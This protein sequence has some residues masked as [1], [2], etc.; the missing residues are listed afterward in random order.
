MT[1]IEPGERFTIAYGKDKKPLEVVAL[2]GRQKRRAVA[3]MASTTGASKPGEILA[4]LDELDAVTRICAPGITDAVMETLDDEL[5]VQ[6]ISATIMK[7][8]ISED[9]EKKSESPHT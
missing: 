8:R 9:E 3:C 4:V 7:A 5:Q 6:I 2:S 1:A